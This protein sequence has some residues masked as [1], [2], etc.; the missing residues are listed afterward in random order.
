MTAF[1]LAVIG[2]TR[3]GNPRLKADVF[4][5]LGVILLAMGPGTPLYGYLYH[6]VPHVSEI[7]G[8]AKLDIV[9]ALGI[10]M[11]AGLGFDSLL[12][13]K[14]QRR[15]WHYFFAVVG[16]LLAAIGLG[17]LFWVQVFPDSWERIFIQIPWLK[18]TMAGLD[19]SLR[20]TF[21]R[22]SCRHIAVSLL[23]GAV[24]SA[25]L[26]GCFLFKKSFRNWGIL[27][28]CVFELLFFAS[29]NRPTF[30]ISTWEKKI[31]A[32]QEFNA[33]HQTDLRIYGTSS[34]SLVGGGQDI[35]EYEPMVLRRYGQ[36]VA[37]SQGLEDNRL[38]SVMPVFS[39][40]TPIFG[41][42]R[43]KYLLSEGSPGLSCQQL[44]FPTLTRFQ[45]ID[46]WEILTEPGAVRNELFQP[47]FD[48][49]HK[50]LL[51][52]NPLFPLGLAGGGKSLSWHEWD[53]EHIEI[54][55]TLTKPSVLLVTDNYSEGWHAIPINK[56]LVNRYQVVPGDYFLQAIPLGAGRHHFMLE[57]KPSAF[58]LGLRISA[59]SGFLYLV[60]L[61][62][63]VR[64]RKRQGQELHE[65]YRL[66]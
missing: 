53:S 20:D 15:N 3:R 42:I 39:R 35:W 55:A 30:S 5:I 22:D 19:P 26:A 51:E 47:R 66:V 52:K 1:I 46:H 56:D 32:L 40:F 31:T 65:Y 4:V 10:A 11:A 43:L 12:K 49:F 27:L 63:L 17:F 6:W 58:S 25:L 50:I 28:L 60:V 21:T 62:E 36:F 16:G 57:Y 24:V 33:N 23:S 38:F 8:W 64:R 29:M 34:D 54:E 44:P 13:E 61:Y 48:F 9:I 14:D 45:W 7:R 41:L 2:W 18:K 37:S 59:L